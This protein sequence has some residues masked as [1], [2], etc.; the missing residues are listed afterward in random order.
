[1]TNSF[2]LGLANTPLTYPASL[3]FQLPQ[4]S[5]KNLPKVK[6]ELPL[7]GILSTVL[8]TRYY[9]PHRMTRWFILKSMLYMQLISMFVRGIF[10][11]F[12]ASSR[13]E[14]M[15]QLDL[16]S[17]FTKDSLLSTTINFIIQIILWYFM[18]LLSNRAAVRWFLKKEK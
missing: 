9:H 13:A 4:R 8:Y 10:L 16:F 5:A 1:M 2:G 12:S 7:L 6:I 15:Q 14:F 3:L 11:A 18:I 17:T